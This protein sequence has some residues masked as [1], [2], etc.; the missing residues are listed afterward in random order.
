[1]KKIALFV[2][3]LIIYASLCFVILC[4]T[5]CMYQVSILCGDGNP[6]M[7]TDKTVT[8]SPELQGNVPISQASA[9][10]SGSSQTQ[11]NP[12]VK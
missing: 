3:C 9:T 4:T 2:G 8:T 5:G 12:V 1:M 7:T 6:V 11:T 10:V